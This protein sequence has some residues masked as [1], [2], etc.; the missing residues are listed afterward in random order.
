VLTVTDDSGA[1]STSSVVVTATVNQA[2]TAVANG[3][4]VRGVFPL[5][6]D[7][8]SAGSVDADCALGGACPGL[9]YSWDFGDGGTSTEANPSHEYVTPATYTATLTVTDN[10]GATATATVSVNV[11]EPNLPPIVTATGTPTSGKEPL[12][13]SFSSAGTVDQELDGTVVGYLWDF[14][15]GSPTSSDPNPS[16]TYTSAGTY[17]ATLTATDNDGGTATAT[18]VTN[19]DPNEAPTA[20]ASADVTGGHSPLTVNFSSVGSSDPE[21]AALTYLWNFGDGATSTEANPTHTYTNSGSETIVRTAT[22]TVT[23]DKNITGTSTVLIDVWPVNQAPAAVIS[24]TPQSGKTPL[25]VSFDAAGSTDVDGSVTAYNW[26]FG[27]GSPTT[28]DVDPTHTYTA[29]GTYTA[30][31]TV[32]DDDGATGSTTQVITVADNVA[33]TADAQVSPAT[34]KAVFDTFTFNGSASTD[35]DGTIVGYA[36]D[37]GDGTTSTNAN[38]TK[39]YATSGV[40]TVTLTV[41]DDNGATGSASTTVTVVDNVAP[42]A[43][44]SVNLTSGGTTTNFNFAANAAD[45]DGTVTSYFW[46]FGN[47]TFATTANVNN[48]KF[49]AAGTYNVTV[50]V[51]DNNGAATTSAPITITIS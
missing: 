21:G 48:K 8:S 18:V 14:G 23:D 1:T 4:P 11:R 26:D 25:T 36:W 28:S 3:A 19:V 40:R 24:A 35:S 15:D 6:V 33:P 38:P 50:T 39:V 46:N 22:L 13:V 12:T 9:S 2:P 43:A 5:T 37:F 27:D 17:T 32:T 45:T 42:S 34:A 31:L 10:E 7:F 49:P 30:T 41:T 51:T 44:P 29:A 47:G 20:V 16:H